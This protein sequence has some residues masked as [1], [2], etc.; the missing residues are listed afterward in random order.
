MDGRRRN[1]ESRLSSLA[2]NAFSITVD[3]EAPRQPPARD[4][5]H[6]LPENAGGKVCQGERWTAKEEGS[7]WFLLVALELLLGRLVAFHR[8]LGVITRPENDE[9]SSEDGVVVRCA[10]GNARLVS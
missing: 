8:M 4:I 10:Q 9:A 7:K 6:G 3:T 2:H 1:Q 5:R